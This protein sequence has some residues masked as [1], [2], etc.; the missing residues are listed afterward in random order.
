MHQSY[1]HLLP[2]DHTPAHA[3]VQRGSGDEREAVDWYG[4]YVPPPHCELRGEQAIGGARGA[5]YSP[6]TKRKP[7]NQAFCLANV[8]PVSARK[9]KKTQLNVFN[10]TM[11]VGKRGRCSCVGRFLKHFSAKFSE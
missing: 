8:S 7:P 5:E 1:I 4:E 11:K 10:P 9:E 3:Q 6:N 2:R